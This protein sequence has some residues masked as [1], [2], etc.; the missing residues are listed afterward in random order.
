MNFLGV[1][2]AVI[3][4]WGAAIGAEQSVYACRRTIAGGLPASESVS[5]TRY[6]E[7]SGER[8]RG[9]AAAA[10]TMTMAAPVG[11]AL[12]LETDRST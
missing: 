11:L 10:F 6:A 2:L 5:L 3:S 4:Y 1:T 7:K 8:R 12:E 9:I